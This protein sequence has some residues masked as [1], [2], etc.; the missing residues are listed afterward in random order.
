MGLNPAA[1]IEAT[2][3]SARKRIISLYPRTSLL[4]L[5][6]QVA[7][8]E[9]LEAAINNH[10]EPGL[11]DG[12]DHEADDQGRAT[13]LDR[14]ARRLVVWWL[15]R[16]PRHQ[17]DQQLRVLEHKVDQTWEF[18]LDFEFLVLSGSLS[19]VKRI[20]CRKSNI[21]RMIHIFSTSETASTWTYYS[22]VTKTLTNSGGGEDEDGACGDDQLGHNAQVTLAPHAVE[23]QEDGG[24]AQHGHEQ[25]HGEPAHADRVVAR[26]PEQVHAPTQRR[27]QKQQVE[28][29]WDGSFS[30][31]QMT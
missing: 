11:E 1:I 2:R 29:S 31:W 26:R 17:I 24:A 3:K 5:A 10:V 23:E 18:S 21:W 27:G 8:L 12:Q 16:V 7:A 30:I 20:K 15:R 19:N 13:N 28:Q 6:P 25:R 4:E 22:Y 9:E 14:R